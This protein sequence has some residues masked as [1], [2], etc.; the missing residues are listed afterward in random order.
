MRQAPRQVTFVDLFAGLGGFHVGLSRQKHV[1]TKCV[2]ACEID[3]DLGA[4]YEVNFNRPCAGDITDVDERDVPPHELLCAGFPCQ[5]FSKAGEQKG[6][7]CGLNGKLF[8]DH[9]LR[10]VRHHRPPLLFL[11][12]VPNLARHD[13]GRTWERMRSLLEREDLG[14]QVGWRVLSPHRYGMPHVRERMYIVASRVGE[15]LG[16]FRWPRESQRVPSIYDVLEDNPED[17]RPLPDHYVAAM[18]VWNEFLKKFPKNH[19]LPSYPI[20][21]MEFGADYPASNDKGFPGLLTERQL[22]RYRGSFG[23]PLSI[24]PNGERFWSLPSYAQEPTFPRWKQTFIR[25][26]RELY[27]ENRSWIRGWKRQLEQFA[28]SLQK[29]EWNC[30][31]ERRD[32]W[33]HVIQFRASGI[34]VKRTT[35]A[36]ALIAMTTTQV[37]VI[38]AYRR[39]MTAR[40]CAALQCL[41]SLEELPASNGRAFRA[42]GNAVNAEMVRRISSQLFKVTPLHV[43]FGKRSQPCRRRIS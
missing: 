36:P 37:P 22:F 10:I 15:R 13:E 12:N 21:A 16:S 3:E 32:I 2:F 19:Q 31:G 43:L 26:N 42:L 8:E 6:L 25:Q 9:L 17:A 23:H 1:R 29:L 18:D 27:A 30:K 11:E 41:E 20:W 39:Y 35:A 33:R 7:S 34:R 14:Y 40:E 38:A 5:P 28:P 24:I 4:H